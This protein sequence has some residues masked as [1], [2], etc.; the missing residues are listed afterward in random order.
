MGR[1]STCAAAARD[2][3]AGASCGSRR[4]GRE[5]LST[6]WISLS[7]P[8]S[9]LLGEEVPS[10]LREPVYFFVPYSAGIL[11]SFVSIKILTTAGSRALREKRGKNV[12]CFFNVLVM[13]FFFFW[14][15]GG[16]CFLCEFVLMIVVYLCLLSFLF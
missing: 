9:Q 13:F 7:F 3:G 8:R 10:C 11:A 6:G 15:G 16:M 12:C 5:P 2:A 4:G 1:G 14:G